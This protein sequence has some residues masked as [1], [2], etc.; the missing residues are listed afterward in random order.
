MCFRLNYKC[1]KCS[2]E[3]E[4]P[5]KNALVKPPEV[6][7]VQLRRFHFL[8]NTNRT[9]KSSNSIDCSEE[10]RV[11]KD[12]G[13]HIKYALRAVIHHQGDTIDSGHYTTVVRSNKQYVW[14]DDNRVKRIYR[15]KR[16]STAYIA[17][18]EAADFETQAKVE[19]H[20]EA[21]KKRNVKCLWSED[22]EISL[23]QYKGI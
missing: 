15:P 2:Y 11:A 16:S 20:A 10:I 8:Q 9:V 23:Q 1:E 13:S 19:S 21:Q 7:M 17:I 5:Q 22:E 4:S 3:G 14:Y 12:D 6:L 18:Y